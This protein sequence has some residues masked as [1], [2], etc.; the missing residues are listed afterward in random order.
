[1]NKSNILKILLSIVA[2]LLISCVL[3]VSIN[4][5][6]DNRKKEQTNSNL[7]INQETNKE[8]KDKQVVVES[9]NE[10][11]SQKEV[12]IQTTESDVQEHTEKVD[13]TTENEQLEIKNVDNNVNNQQVKQNVQQNKSVSNTNKVV[14]SGGTTQNQSTNNGKSSSQSSNNNVSKN[15]N[16]NNNSNN[17]ATAVKQNNNISNYYILNKNSKIFHY[18]TCPSVKKMKDSNKTEL[19]CSRNDAISK[20]YRPCQNCKP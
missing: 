13:S 3:L 15:T 6:N 18:S 11:D 10:I 5:I 16:N 4:L 9:H 20:G 2:G 12:E 14:S 7:E 19:R 17:T 1:M 8:L